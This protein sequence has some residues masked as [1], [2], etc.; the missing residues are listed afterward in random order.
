MFK[1]N[2]QNPV[3]IIDENIVDADGEAAVTYTV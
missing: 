2:V 3:E 1:T